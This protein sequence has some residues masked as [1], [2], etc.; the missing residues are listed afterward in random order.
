MKWDILFKKG[1]FQIYPQRSDAPAE[2]QPG[3]YQI[4]TATG[5]RTV[6]EVFLDWCQPQ[7]GWLTLDVGSGPGYL[8][9]LFA[10]HGCRAIAIDQE[11]AVFFPNRLHDKVAVADGLQLPFAAQSFDLI[12]AS[13]VLFLQPDPKQLLEAM[14]RC[15]KPGGWLA[16]I[17]PSEHLTVPAAKTLADER[18]LSGADRESLISWAERAETNH[19]WSEEN[20]VEIIQQAGLIH[21]RSALK[22]GPGLARFSAARQLS[23]S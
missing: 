5:W 1:G 12:S 8:A 7:P 6:L 4:Q 15:L 21:V 23:Q 14:G 16:L 9:H 18:G 22:M 13:N 2:G 19:R 3:F 10:R 20:L 11:L 17:N